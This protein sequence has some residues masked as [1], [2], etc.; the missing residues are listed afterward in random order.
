MDISKNHLLHLKDKSTKKCDKVVEKRGQLDIVEETSC[1]SAHWQPPAGIPRQGARLTGVVICKTC[2]KVG[3]YT[4][5]LNIH[6][7]IYISSHGKAQDWPG[8]SS[9]KPVTARPTVFIFLNT[10]WV[11][12]TCPSIG[13]KSTLM[14]LTASGRL[15]PDWLSAWWPIAKWSDAWSR[16]VSW[17]AASLLCVLSNVSSNCLPRRMN[18][19][20]D[21]ICLTFLHCEFSN[22]PG[23]QLP[24]GAKVDRKMS[25]EMRRL[26]LQLR[27]CVSVS[28]LLA[29]CTFVPPIRAIKPAPCSKVWRA[30]ARWGQAVHALP[31]GRPHAAHLPIF[32]SLWSPSVMLSVTTWCC[33]HSTVARHMELLSAVQAAHRLIF[34]FPLSLSLFLTLP[35][36]SHL[37]GRDLDYRVYFTSCPGTSLPTELQGK[38]K[39]SLLCSNQH[40]HLDPTSP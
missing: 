15:E 37:F 17:D 21:Y 34:E 24:S 33:W 12:C 31:R 20:S 25:V 16:D 22:V 10:R 6:V 13:F 36:H 5:T 27:R 38:R 2:Q 32:Y 30:Q 39:L 9:V 19:Q 3:T 26:L 1:E 4:Y 7:H 23:G 29:N 40:H 11:S 18:C 8:S 35:H 14:S 28:H